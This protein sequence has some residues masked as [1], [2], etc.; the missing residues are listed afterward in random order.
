M[1]RVDGID[2]DDPSMGRPRQRLVRRRGGVR[3]GDRHLRLRLRHPSERNKLNKR[4]KET[5][6]TLA[7]GLAPAATRVAKMTAN[8]CPEWLPRQVPTVYRKE[9]SP[10]R[11]ATRA[12]RGNH[13][14]FL[15]Y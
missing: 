11:E 14:G 6:N 15:S 2:R 1:P 5:D 8:R 12:M 9:S 3:L 10:G 13:Q 7:A 4:K